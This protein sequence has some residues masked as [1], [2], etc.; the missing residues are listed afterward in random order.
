MANSPLWLAIGF[1]G[2]ALFFG[3]FFVQWLASERLKA[4]V[5]PTSFWY[6][7]IGGGLV[8]LV[9]SIHRHD[10]VFILG[11]ATGLLIYGRNLWF[12]HRLKP[13]GPN[14]GS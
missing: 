14:G 11:Q 5:V 10:P 9:Y 13:T 3:R 6:L 2:Q 4:S 7:S 1:A 8:L 12:I